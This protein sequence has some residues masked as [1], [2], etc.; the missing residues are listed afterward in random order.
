MTNRARDHF[1]WT[2]VLLAALFFALAAPLALAEEEGE[3]KAPAKPRVELETTRGTI[4]VELWPDK[5]PKTVENFLRYVE[6]GFYE[7]TIFHRVIKGFMIQGGGFT[8]GLKQKE[9]HA[10]IELEAN[11]SNDAYTIAMARTNDPDSAT[12]QFYINTVDNTGLN[13]SGRSPGYAVFGKVVEGKSVVDSIENVTTR[14]KGMHR[15][16]PQMTIRIESA[17]RVQ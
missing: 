10:P 4:V 9:T 8:E 11:A 13:P 16:L 12:A 17:E 15:D 6:E 7:G 1:R 3:K 2:W 5:A 14:P